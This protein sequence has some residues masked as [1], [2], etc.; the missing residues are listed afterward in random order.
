MIRA[1]VGVALLIGSAA[2]AD[3]RGYELHNKE[4]KTPAPLIV[5]LQ[6][7]GCPPA[8]VPKVL[9]LDDLAKRH[10]A[11]LA[12]PTAL[13][14]GRGNPFW[15][16]TPACCDFDGQKP[17]DVAY[18]ARVIDDA[19]KKHGADPKQ[20]YLVGISN[21]GFLAHRVACEL[22]PKIAAIVS[23]GGA[24]PTTC[25]PSSPVA[26]LEVHGEHD[27]V[28][29]VAGGKI[30]AGLPQQATIP[31][32]REALEVWARVDGCGVADANGRRRCKRGAA[33]LW[34]LPGGHL[35]ELGDDFAEH[36]WQWLASHRK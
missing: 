29:P 35:P 18:V 25:K 2:H 30:G 19:V 3:D 32:A 13:T 36:L 20:V 27:N 10:N 9:G 6:C 23:I 28:V 21:G 17:D 34:M 24:A 15:N 14:D 11:L 4:A 33:D 16:A 22:S 7:Y 26:V 1:A 12:I 8:H 5:A 31:S